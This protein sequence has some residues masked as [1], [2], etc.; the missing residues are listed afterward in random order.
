[1]NIDISHGHLDRT[2]LISKTKRNDGK[3]IP[4]VIKFAR[5]AVYISVRG[6]K[7]KLQYKNFRLT[8]SLRIARIKALKAVSAKYGMRNVWT[9][10][11][12]IFFSKLVVIKLAYSGHKRGKLG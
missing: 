12:H 3:S 10:D 4:I 8:E 6:N 7:K 11:G 9:S 2:H 5:Y 1:M